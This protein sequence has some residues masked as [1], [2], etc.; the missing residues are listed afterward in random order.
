MPDFPASITKAAKDVAGAAKDVTY[1]V[2]GAGV[3]GVQKIQVHRQELKSK[4]QSPTADLGERLGA[5]REEL[6]GRVQGLDGKVDE[7]MDRAEDLIERL[8]A[9][10]APFE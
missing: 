2:I 8:E 9:V 7:L 1:V 6:T 5:V 10:M 3:L 4:L